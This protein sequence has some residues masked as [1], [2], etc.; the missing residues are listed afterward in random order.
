MNALLA[1]LLFS[2]AALNTKPM[3]VFADVFI[4]SKGP[5]KFLV[6]TGAQTSLIS[7]KLAV[8][9]G[10]QPQFRVEIVTQNSSQLFPGLKTSAL[11]VEG[12][13]LTETELV[14]YD[15]QEARRLDAS[16]QGLLGLNA[17]AGLNFSL[18]PATGRLTLSAERPVG[19]VVP[20]SRIEDRLALKGAMGTDTLTLLLDSGSTHVVLFRIPELM[21][22]TPPVNATY[23]TIDGARSVA[24]TTW[25]PNG[26]SI[27]S[28]RIGM[29]PAAVVQRPG[30]QADGLLPASLFKTVYVDQSR[31]EFVL[32]R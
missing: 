26:F 4:G 21:S 22:K 20:F 16:V 1:G 28:A 27:G 12:H 14:F 7:P 19:E 5:Y 31:N 32:V 8:A 13:P 17:L 30:T 18:S 10:L 11:S 24:P 6:D 29:V 15:L 3:P 25:T 2:T 9:L 23:G